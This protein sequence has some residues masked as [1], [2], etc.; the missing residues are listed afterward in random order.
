MVVIMYTAVQVLRQFLAVRNLR[1]IRCFFPFDAMTEVRRSAC[2]I[3]NKL[4]NNGGGCLIFKL[5][6]LKHRFVFI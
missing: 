6:G 4:A 2:A 3:E 1:I 5:T